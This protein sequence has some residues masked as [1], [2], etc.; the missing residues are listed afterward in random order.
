MKNDSDNADNADGIPKIVV[1]FDSFPI[2]FSF[3]GN[4]VISVPPGSVLEE[5]GVKNGWII[6]QINDTDVHIEG[7]MDVHIEG[8]M[9]VSLLWE[10]EKKDKQSKFKI[11]FASPKPDYSTV[12][13]SQQW[14][15][16]QVP[17]LCTC[18]VDDS[19]SVISPS[20]PIIEKL[21]ENKKKPL[22]V[23]KI[24]M[25]QTFLVVNMQMGYQNQLFLK[26]KSGWVVA[27]CCKLFAEEYF[28]KC[29]YLWKDDKKKIFTRK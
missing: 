18:G 5:K 28:E 4:E 29:G 19:W 12:E 10:I 11:T 25:H 3:Y 6:Q 14:K 23:K 26:K 2:P 16:L 22:E 20:D 21:H 8:L 7:L 9:V 15:N 27:S 13:K 24:K 1:Q 17:F